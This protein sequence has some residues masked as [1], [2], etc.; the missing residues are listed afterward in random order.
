MTHSKHVL[1]TGGTRGI[2]AELLAQY[3]AQG[4]RVYSTGS[5]SQSIDQAA[6]SQPDVQWFAADFSRPEQTHQLG[7]R[8]SGYDFDIVIHNAGLQQPRNLLNEQT[9]PC[10]S[11]EEV[12]I[13][14]TS[15]IVLTSYLLKGLHARQ[16][17]LA[18]ITSGLA[19]AP[20][21]S[22]PIYCAAKAGLRTYVK[23][24]REQARQQ[25]SPILVSEVI[26]TLVD[27]DMT[28]G[29]GAGKIS[30]RQAAAEVI[31][32]ISRGQSEIG[33]DKVRWLMALRCALPN[34]VENML[35]KK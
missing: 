28:R 3:L 8:L 13:N 16:G 26:M 22:S 33:I 9:L 6:R 24:L 29:R 14:L 4:Y 11:E 27:T 12:S 1:I 18:F 35:I 10:S 17:K 5:S 25:H 23:C 21:Q 32:G 34:T 2:G 20:K 7:Q 30:P 31:R 19:I 15:P